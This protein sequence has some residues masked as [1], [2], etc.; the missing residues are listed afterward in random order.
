MKKFPFKNKMLLCICCMLIGSLVTLAGII[1]G[2][3]GFRA[4]ART[5][6]FAAV[7]RLVETRFVGDCDMDE[8]ADAAFSGLI[9]S[10]DDRWSYYMD[11][12]SY[13]AYLDTSANRY[14]GIG[15]TILKDAETA[16]FL[17]VTIQK[18]GP[19][20]QAGLQAGDIIMAVDGTDVTAGDAEA[21]RALIQADY[22]K[23]AL[24]RFRSPDGTEKEVPVSCRE[25]YTNPV[26]SQMLDGHV[27]YVD[28]DNF[29]QGAGQEAIDAIQALLA[30]GA[31]S[32][33]FD[34]RDDP[35]GLVSEL[36]KLLDYLLP[37][38]DLFIQSDRRGHETVD[39]SDADC[40]ELPMAVI[41][42]ENSY[43]AAEFFAAALH[44]YEWAVTVGQP[45]TG[46][47]RS[48]VT[49]GLRDGSAVHL[50]QYSYLTPV[51]TDLYKTGGIVPDVETALDEEQMTLSQTGWLEP[52]DD[53]QV[54]AAVDALVP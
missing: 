35:G 25:I 27:G 32:L 5:A 1:V 29:R 53:P 48:Q 14:Q 23:D 10:L 2:A 7:M 34:V 12:E 46:K 47:A 49:Y 38:G 51:R 43:S 50:S 16:G 54:R 9:A 15:V 40:L 4:F 31:D 19:A 26:N 22:G 39:R 52:A 8:A 24:I 21:L 28:I 20:Q 3:G 37:E 45:T 36:V 33:V 30:Q 17:I 13:A 6:K 18:D 11:P 41:V 42:N 44:D